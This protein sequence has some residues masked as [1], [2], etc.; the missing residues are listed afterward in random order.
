M[1]IETSTE[2]D[3]CEFSGTSIHKEG[4]S[5]KSSGV[6]LIILYGA[7]CSWTMV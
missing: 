7:L 1:T 5:D 2:T 4:C 3:P 6:Y